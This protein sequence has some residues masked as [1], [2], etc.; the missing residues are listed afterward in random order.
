MQNESYRLT[1]LENA[2]TTFRGLVD[3]ERADAAVEADV[4]KRAKPFLDAGWPELPADIHEAAV[5][6]AQTAHDTRVVK[7]QQWIDGEARDL[8]KVI[9]AR[10]EAAA[11]IPA[12][13]G[14]ENSSMQTALM[15][16]MVVATQKAEAERMLSGRTYGEALDLYV[17]T[18][19]QDNP[20]L[21]RLIEDQEA[22]QWKRI[23]LRT[24]PAN[25]DAPLKLTRAIAARR[26]ERVKARD[27][28]AAG[29]A[30]R[31]LKFEHNVVLDSLLRHVRSGR[32][33]ATRPRPR[34]LV[35]VAV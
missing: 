6:L 29:L 8:R 32:G 7:L 4:L 28:E 1:E 13:P 34:R 31:L 17:R 2:G 30:E 3:P 20:E 16:R 35:R 23:P 26:V 11:T 25:A 33:I 14:L 15:A 19:D 24:D 21:V 10:V 5:G 9:G 27:P 18:K 12:E 22:E